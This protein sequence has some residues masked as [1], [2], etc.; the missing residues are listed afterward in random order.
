MTE[1]LLSGALPRRLLLATDLSSR[2][3][4]ALDRAVLLA[5]AWDA[6]LHV[7]HALETPPPSVPAGVD[8]Q[9]YLSQYPDPEAAAARRL[10]ALAEHAGLPLR[11]HV[12]AGPAATAILAVAEREACDLVV[13][14]ETDDG[15]FNLVESTLE[16]VVRK[17]PVSVLVVRERPRGPYR[18]LLVGTDFTEEARQALVVAARLFPQATIALMH[19]W[20]MPYAG[21]LEDASASEAW[22]AEHMARLRGELDAADLPEP[23]RQAIRLLVASG[24]AAVA[25][26]RHVEEHDIDLTV[27]GAHPRG[28]LFDAVVGVSRP[29]LGG[30]PGDILVVRGVRRSAG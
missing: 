23:R 12:E 7:V 14:G 8:E 22:A 26:R 1:R 3:D 13:L 2:G 5:R 17:S 28:L 16:R 15:A 19:A 9:R 6:E 20:V 11:V 27:I 30:I 18:S 25:M 24:V 21:L 4:R 10:R 29:I